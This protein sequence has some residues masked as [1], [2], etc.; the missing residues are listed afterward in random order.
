MADDEEEKE[1]DGD[2]DGDGHGGDEEDEEEDDDDD[3]HGKD[4][5]QRNHARRH[6]CDLFLGPPSLR[7]ASIR[8][9]RSQKG[10]LL[11]S[12]CRILLRRARIQ[13]A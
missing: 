9:A 12:W 7:L 10:S 8:R 5:L 3:E 1:E 6:A 13:E 4:A 11:S 2:A